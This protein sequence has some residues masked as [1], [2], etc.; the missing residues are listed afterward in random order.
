MTEKKRQNIWYGLKIKK[1]VWA[2]GVGICCILLLLVI[3]TG[4][5]ITN[6][7]KEK[8][9]A[10]AYEMVEEK[11][12]PVEL[13]KLIGE[14]KEHTMRL[15][16]ATNTDIYIVAGYGKQSSSGYSIRVND[17][18]KSTNAICVDV[19]LIGPQVREAVT[20]LPTYPYI[21]LKIQKCEESIIFRM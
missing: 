1:S 3:C 11:D 4:C 15:T 6:M 13:K 20:E 16:Y 9:S 14:R 10:I 18:Y 5:K 21:V 7:G 12:I 2:K 8:V 17:V 19:D